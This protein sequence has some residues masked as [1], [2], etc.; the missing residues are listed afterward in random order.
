MTVMMIYDWLVR[1]AESDDFQ[2][3]VHETSWTE[4]TIRDNRLFMTHFGR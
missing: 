4:A 2:L 1:L 3:E